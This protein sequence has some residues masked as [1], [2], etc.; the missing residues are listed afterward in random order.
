MRIHPAAELFPMMTPE[1]LRGLAE[2]I[3][4][5]GLR[6]PIVR[7]EG[8]V[9]DGR[10]RLKACEMEGVTPTFID[11]KPNAE[12]SP[13]AYVLSANLHR[14]HLTPSQKA[15]VAAEALPLFAAEAKVRQQ[16]AAKETN[17]KRKEAQR[18]MTLSAPGR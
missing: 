9:L 6:R 12:E 4:R 1:E 7:F 5:H 2:D 8:T 14:R 18:E 15:I 11:W 3:K 17:R 16:A 10:N 13:T